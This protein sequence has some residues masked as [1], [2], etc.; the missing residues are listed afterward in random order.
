MPT[1]FN[2]E[3]PL[4]EKAPLPDSMVASDNRSQ[5]L[6]MPS[7]NP[8]LRMV[9]QPLLHFLV[10]GALLFGLYFWVGS[11]SR[12]STV[13]PTIDVSAAVVESLKT[14]WRFQWRRS[15]T[16]DELQTL[17]DNYIREQVLYQ[18]ALALGLDQDDLIVRRRLVQKMQFLLEDILP[19]PDPSDAEL[20]TY[21]A[22]HADRYR[23]PGRYSFSHLY[24]SQTERGD[25]AET[26]AR[27]L[28]A[29]LQSTP[30]LDL[31]PTPGDPSLLPRTYTLASAQTLGNTFGGAFAQE[32][33]EITE[34]GWQGLLHS[35][36]GIHLVNVS[37]IEPGH[38]G[39]LAE[40]GK[41]VRLDWERERRQQ[42]DAQSYEALR[43]RYTVSIDPDA[44]P[45]N[46]QEPP[47]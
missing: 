47:K 1:P 43:D 38:P 33:A 4:L 19:I 10:L 34:T 18:E 40:V 28:L 6:P 9:Q 12:A 7:P 31:S 16:P 21:L 23:V 27:D 37:Q 11:P 46:Q 14:T 35:V 30:D 45:P 13:A 39:T 5:S 25:R 44:L 42:L 26:D 20:E 36:Y 22:D 2:S 15:P 24:F 3:A 29:Q 32:M 41:K 8:I 17:V